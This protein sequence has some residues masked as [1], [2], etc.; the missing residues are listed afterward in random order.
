VATNFGHN[1]GGLIAWLLRLT[2]VV[3]LSPQQGADTV[4][5]LAAAPEV[6]DVTGGYFI[7]KRAVTSSKESYDQSIANRLWQIS[8]KMLGL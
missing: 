5:Y 3:A 7:K 8:E 1:N 4:I 6:V 2:Q